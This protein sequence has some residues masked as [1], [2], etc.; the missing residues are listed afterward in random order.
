[1]NKLIIIINGKGGS[2]K[3]TICQIV[4]EIIQ[5]KTISAITPILKIATCGGWTG[6]KDDK[7]RKLLSDLKKIFTDYNDLPFHY[8]LSEVTVFSDD[9]NQLLFVHIREPEEIEKFKHAVAI[10][11]KTLLI[12]RPSIQKKF[13]NNSDALVD[14]YRY[15]YIFKND[16]STLKDLENSVTDFFNIIL[17]EI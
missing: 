2:G 5:T 1:M 3:D 4:S 9:P 15:D 12:N 14:N 6:G 10:P 8:L 17:S 7:S 16:R 11:C 13:G